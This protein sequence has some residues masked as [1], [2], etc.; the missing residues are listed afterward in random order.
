MN[1]NNIKEFLLYVI[2]GGIATVAEW[3]SFFVLDKLSVHY[4]IA[5]TLAYFTGTLV[6]WAAGRIL[7]FKEPN[8]SFIK[9]I[10]SIY[11]AS[12]IG[13]LL[14]LII[15]WIAVDLFDITE[16]VSKIAATGI[17]FMYNFLIRKLLI[18]KK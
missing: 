5:T 17:V 2:V 12:F 13:L 6:N 16:M 1:K 10:V 9:E 18:Y 4:A 14:N 15:M 11:L 8:Q 7:I 3:V